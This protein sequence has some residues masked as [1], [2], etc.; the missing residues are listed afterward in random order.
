MKTTISNDK[1]PASKHIRMKVEALADSGATA[2][3]I[4]FDL[5]KKVNMII[6]EKGESTL[7]NASNKSMDVSGRGEITVCARRAR[8][9]TQDQGIDIKRLV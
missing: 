9:S 6:F 5:A 4:S 1:N 7:T 8:I 2:S 3:I